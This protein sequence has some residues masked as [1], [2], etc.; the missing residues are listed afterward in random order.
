MFKLTVIEHRISSPYHPQTNGL[1]ERTNQ[2]QTRALTKF[3]EAEDNWDENID[4]A[5]YAYR[6]AKQDSSKFSPFFI[7]YNRNP[8]KGIDHEFISKETTTN[9]AGENTCRE[10]TYG[11]L[12]AIRKKYHQKVLKNIARAQECQKTQYDAKH[13]TLHVWNNYGLLCLTIS[14]LAE[15]H[16]WHNGFAE[17]HAKLT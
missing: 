12:L 4:A 1:D 7:M 11:H 13:G 3:A 17:E 10:E 16:H 8:R 2:T 15:F 6:I 9:V 14:N 5:L